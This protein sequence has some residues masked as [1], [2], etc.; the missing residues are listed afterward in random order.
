MLAGPEAGRGGDR[1]PQSLR[2]EPLPPRHADP[3]P[4]TLPGSR[5]PS[6]AGKT[7]ANMRVP[8]W[9]GGGRGQPSEGGEPPCYL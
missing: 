3:V 9:L 4:P 1:S 7:E 2:E 8:V 6:A 5:D